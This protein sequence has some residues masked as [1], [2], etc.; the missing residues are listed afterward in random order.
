MLNAREKQ[1]QAET[2][3][4]D[5]RSRKHRD[6]GHRPGQTADSRRSRNENMTIW[7]A[8]TKV[9]AALS[10]NNASTPHT[11]AEAFSSSRGATPRALVTIIRIP[12]DAADAGFRFLTGVRT[13]VFISPGR[14][15]A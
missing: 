14:P 11:R 10:L 12:S 6:V 7:R 15:A 3:Q 2:Q 5:R 4:S 1:G 8:R 13:Q 9:G